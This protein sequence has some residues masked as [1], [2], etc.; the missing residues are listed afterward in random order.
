MTIYM[1][2]AL[3]GISM[4]E[5][6]V[7]YALAFASMRWAWHR[8]PCTIAVAPQVLSMCSEDNGPFVRGEGQSKFAE[9]VEVVIDKKPFFEKQK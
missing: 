2:T 7:V 8:H 4:A 3:P 6:G 5:G 9:I 1:L